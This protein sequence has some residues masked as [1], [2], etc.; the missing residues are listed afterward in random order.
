MAPG[1]GG[2]SP[3]AGLPGRGSSGARATGRGLARRGEAAMVGLAGGDEGSPGAAEGGTQGTGPRCG[4]GA[5]AEG[6]A[7]AGPG[8]GAG[9]G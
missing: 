7:G 1:R 4:G 8:G 3:W 9:R 6:D 5:G 2:C